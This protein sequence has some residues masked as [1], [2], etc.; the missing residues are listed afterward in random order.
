MTDQR[1]SLFKLY[2]P[3]VNQLEEMLGGEIEIIY[4]DKDTQLVINE[5][6]ELDGAPVNLRATKIY[7]KVHKSGK[8]YG[9]AVILE[10]KAS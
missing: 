10:G 7:R 9:H 6:A 5:M 3:A 2:K 4:I 1:T 8:I